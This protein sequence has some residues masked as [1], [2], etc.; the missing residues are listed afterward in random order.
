MEKAAKDKQKN[1]VFREAE[2]EG[3]S[4]WKETWR[5]KMLHNERTLREALQEAVTR[6]V[7]SKGQA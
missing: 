4:E 6:A 3:T 7:R 1:F 5:R 2:T